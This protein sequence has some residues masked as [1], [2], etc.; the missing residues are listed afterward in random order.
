MENEL[1]QSVVATSVEAT[2]AKYQKTRKEKAPDAGNTNDIYDELKPRN[3]GQ[4]LHHLKRTPF[5]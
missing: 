5:T 4:P 1:I 3:E 2:R